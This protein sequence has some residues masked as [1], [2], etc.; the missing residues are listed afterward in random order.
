MKVKKQCKCCER[1][2]ISEN[3]DKEE[4]CLRCVFEH[5]RIK[6]AERTYIRALDVEEQIAL[7]LLKKMH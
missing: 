3:D 6:K 2:F 7:N 1:E 4:I 5:C